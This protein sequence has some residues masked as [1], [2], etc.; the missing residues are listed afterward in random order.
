MGAHLAVSRSALPALHVSFH[1][2]T[3]APVLSDDAGGIHRCWGWPD[4][5]T[6][7]LPRCG[8]GEAAYLMSPQADQLRARKPSPQDNP[9]S[10]RVDRV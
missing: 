9:V 4:Y 10:P 8:F 6:W 1:P 3:A 7:V 2:A 5:V